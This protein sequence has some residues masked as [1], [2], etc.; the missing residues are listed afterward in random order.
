MGRVL[1]PSGLALMTEN[2]NVIC[3]HL[4]KK[5]KICFRFMKYSYFL[6]VNLKQ[7]GL[8]YDAY[9]PL[10]LPMKRIFNGCL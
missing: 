2:L 6:K 7:K 8:K 3:L 9:W 5:I 1:S 10:T 4:T